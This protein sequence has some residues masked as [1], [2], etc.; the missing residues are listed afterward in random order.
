[1]DDSTARATLKQIEEMG[2]VTWLISGEVEVMLRSGRRWRWR[3]APAV[4]TTIWEFVS[5]DAEPPPDTLLRRWMAGDPVDFDLV[6]AE[7][8]RRLS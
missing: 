4:G 6:L 3:K 8:D 1:M 2:R 5:E 7:C